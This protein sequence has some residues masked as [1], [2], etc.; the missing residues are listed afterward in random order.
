MKWFE[1]KELPDS[2]Y[3]DERESK[4]AD[5]EI[6]ERKGA[7]HG[8]PR[9]AHSSLLGRNRDAQGFYRLFNHEMFRFDTNMIPEACKLYEQLEVGTRP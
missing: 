2:F 9:G 8:G 7:P 3:A 5:S 6:S 4:I 1:G